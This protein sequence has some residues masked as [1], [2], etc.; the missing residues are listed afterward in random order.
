MIFSS[1]LLQ[2]VD[3]KQVMV[4][5]PVESPAGL[6]NQ[7]QY[8]FAN[9]SESIVISVR[10]SVHSIVYLLETPLTSPILLE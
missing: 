5:K 8:D 2:T 6:C 3:V 7:N 9:G 1:S 10:R 4:W